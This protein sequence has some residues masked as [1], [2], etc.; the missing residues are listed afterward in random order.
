MGDAHLP[1][2]ARIARS[3]S[4]TGQLCAWAS[5]CSLRGRGRRLETPIDGANKEGAVRLQGAGVSVA[6]AVAAPTYEC[7]T[8]SR[9]LHESHRVRIDQQPITCCPALHPV[10]GD[11]AATLDPDGDRELEAKEG[12]ERLMRGRRCE[13]RKVG[14]VARKQTLVEAVHTRRKVDGVSFGIVQRDVELSVERPHGGLQDPGS[15]LTRVGGG[16]WSFGPASANR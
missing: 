5:R 11:D 15:K 13:R 14:A 1:R 16:A 12:L 2:V 3:G 7:P 9:T 10:H 6:V 4:Q 8:S